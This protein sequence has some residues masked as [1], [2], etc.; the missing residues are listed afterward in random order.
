MLELESL[1]KDVPDYP[2]PG[3]VFKDI[4]PLLANPAGLAMSVEQMANP[5]RGKGIDLVVGAESRGFIFGTAIA[6]SLSAGFVPI[7]KPNKLPREVRAMEYDLEYGK[8]KL[9]IHADAIKPGQ[10]VL[11][12]DDLLATGGTLDA[13]CQLIDGLGGEIV[14][15]TVLLELSFLPGRDKVKRFG[16]VHAVMT[17]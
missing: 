3:I 1:I 17:F 4:T 5:F 10:K 2:K 8:D 9:E 15:I 6:Q 14:G 7:R 16:D 13:C 11:M 12:V